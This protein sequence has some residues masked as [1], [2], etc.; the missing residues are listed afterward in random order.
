MYP[1]QLKVSSYINM[2]NNV[3]SMDPRVREQSLL[4]IYTSSHILLRQY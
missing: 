2:Y 1:V 4:L 3:Q